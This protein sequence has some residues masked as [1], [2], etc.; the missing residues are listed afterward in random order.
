MENPQFIDPIVEDWRRAMAIS[1]GATSNDVPVMPPP[2]AHRTFW[3]RLCDAMRR[4]YVAYLQWELYR[5]GLVRFD[6]PRER[7]ALRKAEQRRHERK[8]ME[9]EN[10]AA[11]RLL[12]CNQLIEE[13]KRDIAE[14][15][16]VA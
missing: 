2:F 5:L 6:I 16:G 10:E 9:I 8:L 4:A 14:M 11:R 1:S 7:V 3:Q 13:L 15:E 12:E